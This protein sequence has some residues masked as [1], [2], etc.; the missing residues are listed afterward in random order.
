MT[1]PRF[2][3]G[4]VG[5]VIVCA[6]LVVFL[7][8]MACAPASAELHGRQALDRWTQAHVTVVHVHGTGSKWDAQDRTVYIDDTQVNRW[9]AIAPGLGEFLVDHEL[10]GH[11]V[12]LALGLSIGD[13][14]CHAPYWC[15][16][17]ERAAQCVA[18]VVYG[19]GPPADMSSV[20]DGLWDCPSE[21]VERT[22]VLMTAGGVW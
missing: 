7:M 18:E 6:V 8:L 5:C 10:Y 9:E 14:Q 11:P 16:P 17:L 2:G 12:S 21:W 1:R 19:S 20:E 13:E 22:E 4:A 15:P 3:D